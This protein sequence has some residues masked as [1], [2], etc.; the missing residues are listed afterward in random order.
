MTTIAE[1]DLFLLLTHGENFG[2]VIIEA[3]AAGCP[4]LV[5]DRTAWRGLEAAGVGWDVSLCDEER[6]VDILGDC[7]RMN[8]ATHLKMSQA[9]TRLAHATINNRDV[10]EQNRQLF[11]TALCDRKARAR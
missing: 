10:L 5:S 7:V 3:L 4:V 8:A 6:I 2:H 11:R 9:A 1:H